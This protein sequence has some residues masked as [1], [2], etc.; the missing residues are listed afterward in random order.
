[1]INK[2]TI[3]LSVILIAIDEGVKLVVFWL[4]MGTSFVLI[5]NVLLF[6]PVQ[7][8]HLIYLFSLL[9]IKPPLAVMILGVIIAFVI[10]IMMYRYCL[11]IYR[12]QNSI[13]TLSLSFGLAGIIGSFID[14][15]CWGGS[16]DFIRLFNW[17]TFD[18]KDV[19]LSTMALLIILSVLLNMPEYYKL[20]KEDR[21]KLGL[22][23]WIKNGFPTNP[24]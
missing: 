7:N 23:L 13:L 6:R 11:F 2:R 10:V 20:S 9:E 19:Y 21:K 22:I 5:P 15:A 24:V 16:I 18:L 14:I 8:K 1:M 17:F 12:K 4:C 3:C